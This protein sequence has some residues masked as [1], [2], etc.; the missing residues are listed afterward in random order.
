[1]TNKKT[2][3]MKSWIKNILDGIRYSLT[4]IFR[5]SRSTTRPVTLNNHP[6]TN[7]LHSII[8]NTKKQAENAQD[9]LGE[10]GSHY[11]NVIDIANATLPLVPFIASENIEEVAV[12]WSEVAKQTEYSYRWL[13]EAYP[14]T[15][16][17][18]GTTSLTS[19]TTIGIF[20]K[21]IDPFST[22]PSF[23]D[24]W[25]RYI[26][27]TNRPELK[28]EVIDLI[29]DFHLDI[30]PKGKKSALELFQTAHRAFEIPISKNN[31]VITSLVPMRE[32]VESVIDE[33]LRLRPKQEVTG[34]SYSKKILSIGFQLRKEI[35]SDVVVQEWADQWYDISDKDLS[36]SKRYEMTR[37]EWG[38][39]LNRA[40][41]FIYS[42]LTG[43]DPKKLRK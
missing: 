31:P 29:R 16:A 42:F 43:L 37:E 20:S 5:A 30:P 34:S 18:S 35:I 38:R 1:M 11:Q 19:T 8:T 41:Q 4:R 7:Q 13:E 17:A 10:I 22:D 40:T 21:K 6:A 28:E 39:K 15:D 14:S 36:A 3:D 33:L 9:I 25:D 12:L 32:A 27:V 24:A 26:E 23:R 2:L